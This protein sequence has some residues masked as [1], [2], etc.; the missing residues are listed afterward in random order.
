VQNFMESF[1]NRGVHYM[2]KNYQ[3][4]EF[5]AEYEKYGKDPFQVMNN[6]RNYILYNLRRRELS[7]PIKWANT[8]LRMSYLQGIL[9]VKLMLTRI[10]LSKKLFLAEVEMGQETLIKGDVSQDGLPRSFRYYDFVLNYV[11]ENIELEKSQFFGLKKSMQ[12][13]YRT[14]PE[15]SQAFEVGQGAL[16]CRSSGIN[17]RA[18]L[19][20]DHRFS[21]HIKDL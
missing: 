2:F 4:Y 15:L 3:P 9:A 6:H 17:K 12:A 7:K 13:L 20:L 8:I 21:V 19:M 11:K 16:T 5:S 1:S 18:A 10:R 14:Q